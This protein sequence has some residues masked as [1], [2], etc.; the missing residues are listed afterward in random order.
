M[1][2]G[3]KSVD[4]MALAREA[5]HSVRS[6]LPAPV[7]RNSYDERGGSRSNEPTEN[8]AWANRWKELHASVDFAVDADGFWIA[9]SGTF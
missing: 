2:G 7:P 1:N 8:V 4:V 9:V 3:L 6:P 5:G